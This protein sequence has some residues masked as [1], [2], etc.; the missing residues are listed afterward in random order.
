M[1][2]T[3]F[4]LPSQGVWAQ[5]QRYG[6]ELRHPEGTQHKTAQEKELV[7]VGWASYD[8]LRTDLWHV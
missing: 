4:N 5:P 7:E 1:Q 2:V 3:E 6:D 8:S